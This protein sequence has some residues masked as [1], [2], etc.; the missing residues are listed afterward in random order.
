MN[1]LNRLLELAGVELTE[2]QAPPAKGTPEPEDKKP[3]VE[4]KKI[5]T[6]Q[7]KKEKKEKMNKNMAESMVCDIVH[8]YI[9]NLE[10]GHEK[11]FSLVSHI[12]NSD[13]KEIKSVLSKFKVSDS[14]IKEIISLVNKTK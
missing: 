12:V 1:K 3:T 5:G 4:V 13:D 11:V 10:K 7:P 2:R 6:D 9:K 8:K 14:D